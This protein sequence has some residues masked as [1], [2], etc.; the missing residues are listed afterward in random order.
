[1][2]STGQMMR[3]GA[4][5][6][7]SNNIDTTSNAQVT[8]F[9]NGGYELNFLDSPASFI[10]VI[11]MFGRNDIILQV[12]GDGTIFC[13]SEGMLGSFNYGGVRFRNGALYDTTG[14]WP[15]TRLTSIALARDWQ[16]PLEENLLTNPSDICDASSNC[17]PGEAFE[18]TSS[19]RLDD[20]TH[21]PNDER[22]LQSP[23]CDKT[24]DDI[25]ILDP[26]GIMQSACEEDLLL[27]DGNNIFTCQPAYVEPTIIAANPDDFDYSGSG[28]CSD[29]PSEDVDAILVEEV[30]R[31]N[32]GKGHDKGLGKGRGNGLRKRNPFLRGCA[33]LKF[34]GLCD[35]ESLKY[36]CPVTC[37]IC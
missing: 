24:C 32:N 20:E 16:V 18:C 3:V 14:G 9:T 30:E 5:V 6:P 19:R 29:N 34:F 28:T 23:V 21:L 12:R 8:S 17:G 33:R 27:L 31:V 15:A 37:D 7:D 35:D 13:N 11:K 1:M 25:G 22:E 4:T 2:K 10:R 36:Q 26:T